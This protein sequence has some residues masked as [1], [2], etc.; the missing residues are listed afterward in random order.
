M[1]T[2]RFKTNLT[3]N[4]RSKVEAIL[5]KLESIQWQFELEK[6]EKILIVTGAPL[7]EEIIDAITQGGYEI[8]LMPGNFDWSLVNKKPLAGD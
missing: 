1:Q 2:L 4:D 5:Q 8:E 3:E 7:P 6:P